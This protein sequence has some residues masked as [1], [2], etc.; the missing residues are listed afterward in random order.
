MVY[1]G[2]LL[3]NPRNIDPGCAAR[4]AIMSALVQSCIGCLLRPREMDDARIIAG[5]AVH[6]NTLGL[7]DIFGYNWYRFHIF[8]NME[9]L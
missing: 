2:S 7:R 6:I 3:N 8:D 5:L 9:E 1:S 4:E